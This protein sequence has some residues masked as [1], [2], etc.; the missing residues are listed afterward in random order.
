MTRQDGIMYVVAESTTY[1]EIVLGRAAAMRK[2]NLELANFYFSIEVD[3][4]KHRGH[5]RAVEA[6]RK[7]NFQ[8]IQAGE[9]PLCSFDNT[10]DCRAMVGKLCCELAGHPEAVQ[11]VF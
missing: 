8:L 1:V 9:E 4:E 7:V 5:D 6:V 10:D 2:Q 3:R 11:Y